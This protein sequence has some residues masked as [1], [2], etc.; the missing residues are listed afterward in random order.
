V[1][2]VLTNHRFQGFD[3]AVGELQCGSEEPD[4]RAWV[5]WNFVAPK[6]FCFAPF[7]RARASNLAEQFVAASDD[8]QTTG[9]NRRNFVPIL[10]E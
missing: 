6:T 3:G 1:I 2:S 5:Q 7:G 9:F 10:L 8:E 4:A